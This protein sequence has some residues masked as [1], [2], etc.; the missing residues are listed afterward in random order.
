MAHR[1]MHIQLATRG[2]NL[3]VTSTT[4]RTASVTDATQLTGG[5]QAIG[6]GQVADWAALER[7]LHDAIYMQVGCAWLLSS[8][9][10]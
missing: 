7:I 5:V 9:F 4:L 3:Q 1:G 2:C 8:T 10:S 6:N